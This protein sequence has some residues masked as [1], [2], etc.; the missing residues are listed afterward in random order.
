MPGSPLL[1]KSLKEIAK[2]GTAVPPNPNFDMET[3]DF[4]DQNSHNLTPRVLVK[5]ARALRLDL[6]V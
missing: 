1:R 4:I 2:P 3:L 6:N 5:A